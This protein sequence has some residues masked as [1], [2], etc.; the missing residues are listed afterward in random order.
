MPSAMLLIGSIVYFNPRTRAGCD[1]NCRKQRPSM[2]R[3]QSTH[4][5]WVRRQ[6][7]GQRKESRRNFNP[8]TRAGCDQTI[9]RPK[10]SPSK[11]QSTHPCWVRLDAI[12]DDLRKTTISIHA[13]VLGATPARRP[14]LW[15]STSKFQSTHPCWVRPHVDF[16]FLRATINFNPR[17]RAGCDAGGWN[18][19]R[20]HLNFNPRTRA[21]CDP[22]FLS[23]LSRSSP[24]SIHAPVLGATSRYD[25]AIYKHELFQ[26]T[27]PYWV[28]RRRRPSPRPAAPGF[29]S[30]HPCWVRL[31]WLV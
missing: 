21:G 9:S 31:A 2:P 8:R 1:P 7:Y 15:A 30:T 20:L 16:P 25:S 24:I 4:P 26:S 5:C 13:P 17:T 28:R 10:T 29:Q 18:I 14:R 3:F 12:Y 23:S 6:V 11:F 19:Q 27:H 22:I